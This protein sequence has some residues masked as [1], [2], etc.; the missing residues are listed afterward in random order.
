MSANGFKVLT[1]IVASVGAW[2]GGI[3]FWQPII[4]YVYY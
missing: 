2:Y 4:V 3:K 1:L